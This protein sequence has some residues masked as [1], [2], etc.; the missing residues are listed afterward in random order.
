MDDYVGLRQGAPAGFVEAETVAP[1]V[2]GDGA[3]PLADHLGKLIAELCAQPVEAVV[4]DDLAGEPSGCVGTAAGPH[5]NG[6]L[7]AGYTAE[8]P[9][10][11]G[12]PQEA[13][14]PRDEEALPREVPLDGHQNCLPPRA[15]S[16]YHLV[17]DQLPALPFHQRPHP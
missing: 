9:L 4:L 11:Q 14:R 17:S 15:E 8:D 2:T 3:H 5:E 7:R 6:H 10:D 1:D 13:G 16:V 12:C